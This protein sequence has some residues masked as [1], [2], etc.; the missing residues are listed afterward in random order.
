MALTLCALAGAET[1]S[2]MGLL[3]ACTVWYPEALVLDADLHERVRVDLGDLRHRPGGA[4]ARRHPRGRAAR[5]LPRRPAHARRAAGDVVLAA[6]GTGRRRWDRTGIRS[7]SHAP[8]RSGSSRRTSPSRSTTPR[9]SELGPDR[10]R[11]A[12]ADAAVAG[13]T[14][15]GRARDDDRRRPV[16]RPAGARPRTRAGDPRHVGVRVDSARARRLLAGAGAV[17]RAA[18]GRVTFPR[19]LVE[20][21]RR[22]AARVHARRPP[23]GLVAPGR[24]GGVHAR[25]RR[26]GDGRLGC[27]RRERRPPTIADWEGATRV[28]DALDEVGV[29]WRTTTWD[30]EGPAGAVSSWRR[31]FGE[32]GK[33]V[34]DAALDANEGRWLVEVLQVVFGGREEIAARRPF[35]FLFCPHSP[36]VLEGPYTDAY[37]EVAGWGI[38]VAAM[39]MPIMGLSARPGSSR[40][41]RWA[42]PRSSRPSASCRRRPGDAVRRRARSR[43]HG[44][45][46]RTVRR[47]GGRARVARRL[48]GRDGA[49]RG[50]ARGVVHRRDGPPRPRDPGR[51]RARA[52]LVA[53]R[54]RVARPARRARHA[55]WLDDPE[56][57]A[58]LPRR[59]GLPALSPAPRRRRSARRPASTGWW[60]S[61]RASGRA[62]TS[63]R[64]RRRATRCGPGRGCW[65]RPAS[66]TGSSG[67]RRRAGPTSSRRPANGSR[68]PSPPASRTRSPRRSSASCAARGEGSRGPPPAPGGG[69]APP[70][71]AVV[72]AGRPAR[73]TEG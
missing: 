63:L 67:G 28:C 59:R 60:T 23:A 37:L 48:H 73:P 38:P 49:A 44:A 33:H 20:H 40:R 62:A 10:P 13:R 39:P 56:H 51:V 26:G 30:E 8:R 47:R 24:R 68:R 54:A 14:A 34:Q 57:R 53:P 7:P 16:A 32:F 65:A 3:D 2:G 35:S 11:A 43:G 69:E 5:P 66:T 6:D 25:R 42:T 31:A 41:S 36:L 50:I 4:R 21:S 27:G 18:D 58:A 71:A 55:R 9:A 52:Q 64:S 29:Y 19:G 17:V 22:C 46:E 45:A 70:R 61:S 72:T 1:G 12:D 15:A